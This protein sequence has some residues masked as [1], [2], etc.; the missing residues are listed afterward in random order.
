M[1]YPPF[2]SFS[3]LVMLMNFDALRILI[4]IIIGIA[5]VLGAVNVHRIKTNA[6][7]KAACES[8]TSSQSWTVDAT[9]CPPTTDCQT[10]VVKNVNDLSVCHSFDQPVGTACESQCYAEGATKACDS[11]HQCSST[12]RSACLGYCEVTTPDWAIY[13]LSHPDC[14]GKLKFKPFFVWNETNSSNIHAKHL[15]YSQ[16]SPDCYAEH[17][18]RWYATALRAY[19]IPGDPGDW[20]LLTGGFYDCLDFLEMDNLECI[21][22][23]TLEMGSNFSDPLFRSILDPYMTENIT[24]WHFQATI[25]NYWYK[26]ALNN[27][28]YYSDPQYIWN[29]TKRDITDSSVR[30][31]P[32]MRH[33]RTLH[34]FVDHVEE[35]AKEIGRALDKKFEEYS[36]ND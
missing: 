9:A 20:Y 23:F 32:V 6:V 27:Q 16:L 29:G 36:K 3:S 15:Y 12:N 25:C 4:G 2:E 8:T 33:E 35:N 5:V 30:A 19:F 13:Q 31:T 26:C 22:A 21:E 28:T 14:E 17:G 18:C 34:R 7:T 24:N 11:D 1:V 10:G